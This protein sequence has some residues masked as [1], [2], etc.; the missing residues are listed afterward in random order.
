M[1]NARLS[2]AA[3]ILLRGI[4]LFFG[5]L[6]LGFAVFVVYYPAISGPFIFDDSATIVDNP[7]IRQLW[8]LVGNGESSGPLNSSKATAIHGRPLVSLSLAVNYYFGGL[9]PFGYRIVHI[10][11][12]FLATVLLWRIVAATLRL[13]YFQGRF[14]RS[15]EPLSFA[16]AIV[17]AMHPVNTESIVYVTQRTE[18]MMGM[19][20]LATI[21]CSIR[22]WSTS[23]KTARAACLLTA[24]L[25]CLSGM[26]C[27]EMMA[28]APAMVL[29]YERTFI[30]GSFRRALRR[31][32]PLYVGLSLAWVP[33]LALNYNGARTPASGFGMGVAAHEWWF[34]QAKVIFLYLKLA[35]WPWPLVIHYEIPYLETV[36]EAWPWLLMAGLLM[37]AT[38]V[39]FWRRSATGFVA[40]WFFAIL[41]PTLV[42]PLVNEI[43]AERR[44][45]VPLAAIVPLLIIGGYLAQQRIWRSVVRRAELDSFRSGSVV[46]FSIAII[47]LAIGFAY[48]SSNRLVAY[49]DELSIWQD[50]AVHQPHNSVV[51]QNLGIQLAQAG[52]LKDA[53]LHLEEAVRL[54]PDSHRAHFNLALSLEQSARFQDAID[55]Y[56][57]TL[58]LCPDD[59]ASHYNLARLL[60]NTGHTLQAI[61][62]YRLAIAA[63][64]D[65]HAAHTNLGS[66]LLL[67][68]H[69]QESIRHFEAALREQKD[70]ANYI[71]LAMAY[72]YVNRVADAIPMAEKALDLA[73][74]QGNKSLTREIEGVLARYRAQ[75][76]TP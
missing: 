69:Q 20:Y 59:P 31:S 60:A 67:T 53:I 42:I 25:A 14:E 37:L 21:Y 8:P 57:T 22:Y 43:A 15:A 55:H 64:S 40:V 3:S 41:S 17:W 28:S 56:R 73:R 51:R 72:S 7:S 5:I 26:L 9:D 24:T 52:Q 1:P 54:T 47:A 13:D 76:S 6:V 62:H 29:L 75:C 30:V 71:N 23:R 19:F 70:M 35:V 65:F 48:L 38:L 36:A 39:L 32:W 66:L 68:G 4:I 33:V 58:R 45:Y 27:K 50:A 46:M 63:Q 16:A 10:V 74:S 18:L 2:A 34:T 11:V 49:Q 61:S 44:M 12:H